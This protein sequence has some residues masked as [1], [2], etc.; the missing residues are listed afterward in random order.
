MFEMNNNYDVSVDK[1]VGLRF[2]FIWHFVCVVV[3]SDPAA[4]DMLEKCGGNDDTVSDTY[5]G[6]FIA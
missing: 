1:F 5:S 3:F 4:W 2:I 6:L